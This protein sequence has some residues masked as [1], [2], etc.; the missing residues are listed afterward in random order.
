MIE[1][2]VSCH[3]YVC[4]CVCLFI[5]LFCAKPVHLVSNYGLYSQLAHI[6]KV[7]RRLEISHEE[8]YTCH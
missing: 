1:P 5:Y 3:A 2:E 4:V 6:K 7:L 8:I